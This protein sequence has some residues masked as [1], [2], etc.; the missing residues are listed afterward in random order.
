MYKKLNITLNEL[1]IL[2]VFTKGLDK[3]YYIRELSSILAI[4]VRTVYLTLKSLETKG[5]LKSRITWKLRFYMIN[6]KNYPSF[7]YLTMAESYKLLEFFNR[8]YEYK[9]LF[10]ELSTLYPDAILLVFGSYAKMA[11]TKE[12]DLDLFCICDAILQKEKTDMITSKCSVKVNI[13]YSSLK[14]FSKED[15]LTKE[16]ILNHICMQNMENYLRLIW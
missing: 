1:R 2:G 5:V 9:Q 13:K 7:F 12:S 3:E 8:H 14:N 10:Y 11:E 6:R 16:V 4:N 15:I